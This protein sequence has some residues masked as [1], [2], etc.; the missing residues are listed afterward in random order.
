MRILVVEDDFLIAEQ[1]AFEIRQLGDDVLGPFSNIGGAIGA[2]QNADA[3]ILDV[4]VRDGTSFPVADH[5]VAARRPFIFLTGYNPKVVPDRFGDATLYN[6]PSPTYVLLADLHSQKARPQ[7]EPALEDTVME[8]M[9]R[10]RRQIQ[11]EAAAERLVE[12][13]LRDTI[14]LVETIGLNVD[15][16]IWLLARLDEELTQ[17]H[18][19]HMH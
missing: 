10:A 9:G 18:Y 13:V 15:V 7:S 17:R 19:I 4:R 11:D 2:V 6:K 14:K 1:L 12:A 16:H 5:L 3:A 8:M